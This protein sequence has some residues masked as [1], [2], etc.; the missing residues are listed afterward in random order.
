MKKISSFNVM[1][2]VTITCSIVIDAESLSGAV[3]MAKDL[4]Y[5]DFVTI[6]GEHL[7]CPFVYGHHGNFRITGVYE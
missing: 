2:E 6:K 5:D 1:A 7:I 3:E 4:R